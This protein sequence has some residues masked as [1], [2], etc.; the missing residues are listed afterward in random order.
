MLNSKVSDRRKNFIQFSRQGGR[1]KRWQFNYHITRQ[2]D[3]AISFYAVNA[4]SFYANAVV[5]V[6]RCKDFFARFFGTSCS[7]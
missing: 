1:S 7:L 2:V 5:P 3:S 4:C 6:A